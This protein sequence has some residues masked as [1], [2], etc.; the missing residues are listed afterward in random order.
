MTS[1]NPFKW[2]GVTA[3]LGIQTGVIVKGQSD[4]AHGRLLLSTIGASENHVTVTWDMHNNDSDEY[5]YFVKL[6]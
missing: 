6:E 2:D 5:A 4:V 3:G 1:G